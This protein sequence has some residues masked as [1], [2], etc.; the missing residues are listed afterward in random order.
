MVFNLQVCLLKRQFVTL[1]A[2]LMCLL[3]VNDFSLF[4]FFFLFSFT[5]QHL[6][7]FLFCF[8]HVPKWNRSTLILGVEL[9]STCQ[10]QSLGG[11]YR[12][13]SRCS[14][15]PLITS[16]AVSPSNCA[17]AIQI[18]KTRYPGI[19]S[20]AVS[21]FTCQ[22]TCGGTEFPLRN[23]RSHDCC[24]I[25]T[26][27]GGDQGSVCPGLEPISPLLLPKYGQIYCRCLTG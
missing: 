15:C 25:V 6:F 2:L 16:M 4:P 27:L 5:F 24:S 13:A 10:V 14:A 18:Q 21:R 20:V 22:K 19:L 26:E 11:L 12:H 1:L 7:F 23:Q 8:F 3:C 17:Q 9:M